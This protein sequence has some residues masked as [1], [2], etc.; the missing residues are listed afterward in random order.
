MYVSL[1]S[2]PHPKPRN[3]QFPSS[4]LPKIVLN[5]LDLSLLLSASGKQGYF[6]LGS[7]I[8]S[9][10][11][12]NPEIFNPN[13]DSKD[14]NNALVVWNSLLGMY[15]RCGTLT[16]LTNL[17]DEMPMRDTVSWNTLV[18]GFLRDGEFDKGFACFKQMRKLSFCW[19]DQA[20][21]T[22][23]LSACGRVE[24]CYIVKMMHGLV[25]LNGFEKETSVGNSLITSYFKCGCVS[26]GR[27]VF[28]DMFE[29]NVIYLDS[30]DL[31]VSAK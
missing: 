25:F 24:F 12:K 16:D 22:T 6:L 8:H 19:F 7:S 28:D 17:F 9:S 4:D 30:Y 27:R 18:S 26:S 14:S 11:I 21:L 2:S 23:I 15:S 13:E 10:F 31:R 5:H 3:S 20:I 29:R 1:P